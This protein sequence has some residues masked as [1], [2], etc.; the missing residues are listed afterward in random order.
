M[1]K[2]LKVAIVHEWLSTYAGSERV[3]EQM[4]QIFPQA[5]IFAVVDFLP[6]KERAFLQGRKVHTSFIQ[7]LPFAK[8]YFRHYLVLMP[9]AV[10]QFDL[11]SFDLVLSSSH[12]VAKG[13]LTG[14]N[15]VH[16]SYVHSP[17][18]Y[19]WDLQSQYLQ[20]SGLTKGIKAAI[21][22]LSLHYM[23]LW[24]TRTSHGVNQFI[25]N[26]A[27]I[28][29]RIHKIY[30]RDSSVVYPPVDVRAFA[31]NVPKGDYFLAAAR[32]VPYKKI[33]LIVEA[34]SKMPEHRLIVIG[35]GQDFARCQ[36]LATPNITVLGFQS[37]AT[38]RDHMQK[39]RAY[40]FAGEED[41]GITLVEAQAAGTPVIAFGRGGARETV[42]P[43][44]G[45]AAPTGVFFKSQTVESLIQAVR[46]F[47]AH[48]SEITSQACIDNAAAFSPEK[49]RQELTAS[50]RLAMEEFA[51]DLTSDDD[52]IEVEAVTGEQTDEQIDGQ[53]DATDDL[54]AANTALSKA[55]VSETLV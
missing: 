2:N 41:F 31:G 12:A 13:V 28:G 18:R 48:E 7:R 46:R 23:R 51:I 24:D 37:F 11:S 43:L 35:D 30:G 38:L 36:A 53:T 27:Y 17:I 16:V 15:Q 42:R 5:E 47:V 50:L 21:V 25:A 14:P 3:V 33:P 32:M 44:G 55:R 34:F 1:M 40:V 49:F 10:E 4:I 9:L 6:P 39:A 45:E 54:K 26:S 19:A 8:K 20:E 52:A 29:R 22:R